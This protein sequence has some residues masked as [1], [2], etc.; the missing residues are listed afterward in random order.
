M[1]VIGAYHLKDDTPIWTALWRAYTLCKYVETD[2]DTVF[3]RSK[4]I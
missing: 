1:R 3:Y 4:P 2:K